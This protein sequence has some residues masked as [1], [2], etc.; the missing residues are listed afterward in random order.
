MLLRLAKEGST[1]KLYWHDPPVGNE[2]VFWDNK[3]SRV[4]LANVEKFEV[5]FRPEHGDG[6]QSNDWDSNA[7][8]PAL[9]RL[10]IIAN[11][12]YWPDLILRVQR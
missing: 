9:V 12:R 8:A 4:L 3:S 5:S 10:A 2:K 6:W 11:G 1:L 7:G